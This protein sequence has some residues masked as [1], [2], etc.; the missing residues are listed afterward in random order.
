MESARFDRYLAA[1]DPDTVVNQVKTFIQ[2]GAEH[3][4]VHVAH[5]DLLAQIDVWGK[6]VLPNFAAHE[7]RES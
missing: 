6:Y 3:I 1:G 5:P 2:A 4:E 7:G